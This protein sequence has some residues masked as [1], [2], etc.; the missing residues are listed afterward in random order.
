MI[1]E[2]ISDF[3]EADFLSP[4]LKQALRYLKEH[5]LKA[6]PLGKTTIEG[7]KLYLN[8]Q[9]YQGK[10]EKDAR[11]EAHERYWDLQILLQGQEYLDY[12]SPENQA[13]RLLTPY[14]PENDIAF[15]SGKADRRLLFGAGEMILLAPGEYHAPGIKVD[16]QAIEKIVIKIEKD[17]GIAR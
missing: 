2:K 13:L 7:T 12:A 17:T 5:D 10:E 16:D 4:N 3:H 1:H 11:M 8:H 14:D 6:L 9:I 15:Y